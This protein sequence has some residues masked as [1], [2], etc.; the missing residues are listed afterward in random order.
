MISPW[1]PLPALLHRRRS[2]GP[3]LRLR[4]HFATGDDGK[5][6]GGRYASVGSLEYNYRFSEK[7]L[8]A[9]FVDAGTATVD[10][11]E[12]WKIGTGVGVRWVTPIGQVRLD[13]AVGISEEDKPLRLHFALGPEL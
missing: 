11:S 4:D 3:G 8:G 7:W 2:D 13:L 12:A 9:L 5:L 6:T 10:Y 1:S